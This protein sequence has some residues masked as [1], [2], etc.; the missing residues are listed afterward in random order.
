MEK[1]EYD[2]EVLEFLES[3]EY[4]IN[5][6]HSAFNFRDHVSDVRSVVNR[7][8]PNSSFPIIFFLAFMACINTHQ[9]RPHLQVIQVPGP[10]VQIFD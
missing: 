1:E 9:L 10:L 5:E 3:N 2:S 4:T 6:V 8:V 7:S